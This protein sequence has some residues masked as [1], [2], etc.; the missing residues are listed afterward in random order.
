MNAYQIQIATCG[1][2]LWCALEIIE[3][4]LVAKLFAQ[5]RP[6]RQRGSQ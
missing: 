2:H 4:K 3:F 1:Q 6:Q 5:F